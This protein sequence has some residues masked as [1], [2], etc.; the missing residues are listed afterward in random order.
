MLVVVLIPGEG[1]GATLECVKLSEFREFRLSLSPFPHAI[2][3]HSSPIE[4][5]V[6]V[7]AF[8][9]A[10]AASALFNLNFF[11]SIFVRRFIYHDLSLSLSLTL[12]SSLRPPPPPPGR[13][14][15]LPVF[16]LPSVVVRPRVHYGDRA[17]FAHLVVDRSSCHFL[18]L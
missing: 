2:S 14:L 9:T 8:A 6:M 13:S 10:A 5:V 11:R 12:P 4:I 17:C 1:G 15:A 18:S 16:L 3:A 7:F